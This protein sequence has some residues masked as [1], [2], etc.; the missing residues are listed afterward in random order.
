MNTQQGAEGAGGVEGD[1]P[2]RGDGGVDERVAQLEAERNEL[3]DKYLRTLADYHNSQRR[4]VANEREARVQGVTGVVLNVLPVLDNFDLALGQ[5]PAKATAQQ[6][7]GG[8]KLIRDELVRVLQNQGVSVISPAPNSEF[9]P[10]QHQAVVQM[11]AESVE[12]GRIVATLQPGYMLG[13]R[14]I[15]PAKVSVKPQE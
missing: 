4:A 10:N 7:I 14:V 2:A 8:V 11:H 1:P 3:N 13:E 15:R 9:D 5:D 6:I 12:P